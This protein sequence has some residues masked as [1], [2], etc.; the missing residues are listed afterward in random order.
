MQPDRCNFPITFSISAEHDCCFGK[1]VGNC[2]QRLDKLSTKLEYLVIS[3]VEKYRI[4]YI[5]IY[6]TFV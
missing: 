2:S 3:Y 1:G 6:I 4:L 5:Y